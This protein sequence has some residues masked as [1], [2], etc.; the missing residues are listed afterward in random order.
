[1]STVAVAVL[2]LASVAMFIA[3]IQRIGLLQIS[4]TLVFTVNQG[5]KVINNSRAVSLD[6][7]AAVIG[8]DEF[9]GLPRAQTLVDDGVP[10]SLQAIDAA[11]SVNLARESCGAD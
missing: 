8:A 2:L 5:W 3:L 4:R 11:A 7:R 9:Q 10:R 1:M 6:S